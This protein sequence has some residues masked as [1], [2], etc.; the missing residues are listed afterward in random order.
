MVKQRS[1]SS[2]RSR[3]SSVHR[4]NDACRAWTFTMEKRAILVDTF[5][6]GHYL[7]HENVSTLFWTVDSAQGTFHTNQQVSIFYLISRPFE[8]A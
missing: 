5:D 3:E 4:K 1:R 8:S 7:V 2:Q 6:A